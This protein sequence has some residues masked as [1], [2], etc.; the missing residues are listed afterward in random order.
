MDNHFYQSHEYSR[1]NQEQEPEYETFDNDDLGSV[2][3]LPKEEFAELLKPSK[4]PQ[5][6]RLPQDLL[7]KSV[8]NVSN[9]PFATFPG[10]ENDTPLVNRSSLS[11][12]LLSSSPSGGGLLSSSWPPRPSIELVSRSVKRWKTSHKVS[13]LPSH[14]QKSAS[15]NAWD[16]SE[17]SNAADSASAAFELGYGRAERPMR[18]GVSGTYFLKRGDEKESVLCVFKPVDEEPENPEDSRSSAYSD[19]SMG[20]WRHHLAGFH[21]GEGAYKEVAAYLLDHDNFAGV[22]QTAL[23]KCQLPL[24]YTP[25]HDSR[26]TDEYTWGDEDDGRLRTKMGAFQAYVPNVGD[27]DDFGP[28][29]LPKE[30]ASRIAVFDIRT[31]NHDRHGG[32]ILVRKAK[33][34]GYDLVPI[35]HGYILPSV[36]S[37]CQWPI[38]MDWPCSREPV[39]ES[40][41]NYV[42]NLSAEHDAKILHEEIP[43]ISRASLLHLKFATMLLQK[44]L[45]NDLTLFEIGTLIFSR[46][47][48]QEDVRSELAKI[49]EESIDAGRS[50]TR[51]MEIFRQ[52]NG[53]VGN[54]KNSRPTSP[55][56]D[57][58]DTHG[59]GRETMESLSDD[60]PEMCEDYMLK[61]AGRLIDRV[62]SR[63]KMEKM[64]RAAGDGK[65]NGKNGNSTGSTRKSRGLMRARSIP[66]YVFQEL[67]KLEKT[68]S[69]RALPPPGLLRAKSDTTGYE[70]SKPLRALLRTA[71]P[72]P[73]TC[74]K[75]GLQKMKS[76]GGD[77]KQSPLSVRGIDWSVGDVVS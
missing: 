77:R 16:F 29:V 8:P 66:D 74:G 73:T 15:F 52:G 4:A 47:S 25:L 6:S 56:W 21:A 51:H 24:T 43:Q 70:N 64:S 54:G 17:L 63:I 42:N 60:M 69:R 13:I 38:W 48:D 22:P 11:S 5:P 20:T 2:A 40:I 12:T 18:E 9:N 44:G 55:K 46:D 7:G 61:Y 62:V 39:S 32:N 53:E 33:E 35:D 71:S 50:R 45:K 26:G 3:L 36:F 23:A 65:L 10:D 57:C 67:M 68:T 58:E 76:V 30:Q 19:Y 1:F 49:I 27:A 41:K 75:M 28:L 14:E 59:D 72:R 37:S 34:G 31:L